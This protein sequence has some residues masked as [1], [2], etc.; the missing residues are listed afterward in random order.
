M[1]IILTGA[2]G[3]IG[4]EV[5]A[6]LLTND[7]TNKIVCLVRRSRSNSAQQR[8]AILTKSI[9]T[10]MGLNLDNIQRQ[11]I[12]IDTTTDPPR[13]YKSILEYLQKEHKKQD[14]G[15]LHLASNTN[16]SP[17]PNVE[18]DIFNDCYLPALDLLTILSPYIAQY[19]F[20][21]TAFSCGHQKGEI[22]NEYLGGIIPNNRNYYE[23]LKH[24]AELKIKQICEEKQI[25]WQILRPSIVSGRLIRGPYYYTPK[26][27]VF[28]AW[29]GFFN[30][31][32]MNNVDCDGIR[33]L[34]NQNTGINIIP[35]DYVAK[36]IS[37]AFYRADITELNLTHTKVFDNKVLLPTM[38]NRI[39]VKNYEFVDQMPEKFTLAEK[40]YYKTAGLQFS[41]YLSTYEHQYDS[42]KVRQ[43][44]NDI[45]EPS[46]H[47]HFEQ[48]FEFA[49]EKNFVD[50][51]I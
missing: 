41:P 33:I 37:R 42:T 48:L 34:V 7:S 1:N 18:D 45:S 23:R 8:I 17:L 25:K 14:W 21:S 26:F 5:L 9:A 11:V 22:P 32:K 13:S 35:S 2:T 47:D 30:S 3:I 20:V 6:E 29:G 50:E 46:I 31:L 28:Y 44:M 15:V 19:S 36:A 4:R 38:L 40:L 39:G 16:L 51:S 43:V 10:E 24:Q 12:V 49:M 27:N